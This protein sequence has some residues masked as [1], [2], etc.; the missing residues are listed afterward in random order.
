MEPWPAPTIEFHSCVASLM[1]ALWEP[2]P[3]P[4]GAWYV[5]LGCL[6]GALWEPIPGPKGAWMEPGVQP[7][8]EPGRE[9]GRL[10]GGGPGGGPGREPGR[11]PG[12]GGCAWYVALGCLMG[13][14]W[15][16]R[17]APEGAWYGAHWGLGTINFIWELGSP[18]GAQTRLRGSLVCSPG[19]L[20]GS[21]MGA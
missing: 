2:R 20:H 3:G 7:G 9:P 15:E 17:P 18:L 11:E 19:Q 13:A 16:P 10:P 14:L 21:L 6:M 8:R 12:R 4:K 5:A 1:G